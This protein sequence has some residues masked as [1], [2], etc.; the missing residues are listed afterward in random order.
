M[1]VSKPEN[2]LIVF[3]VHKKTIRLSEWLY[4]E[5][6]KNSYQLLNRKPKL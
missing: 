4:H 3:S 1:N 5:K 2:L 6:L